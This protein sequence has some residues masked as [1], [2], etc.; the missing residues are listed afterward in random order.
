MVPS[1]VAGPALALV[2]L[3]VLMASVFYWNSG[4][5]IAASLVVVAGVAFLVGFWFL[6]KSPAERELLMSRGISVNW[7]GIKKGGTV[8][9]L[10]CLMIAAGSP[11]NTE[12]DWSLIGFGFCG[13]VWG[14]VWVVASLRD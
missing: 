1:W 13:V 3:F 7:Q 2:S 11:R 8:L 6:W 12:L 4:N 14:I 9:I 5:R 10:S